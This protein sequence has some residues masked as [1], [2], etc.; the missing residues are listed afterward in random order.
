MTSFE[1][2]IHQGRYSRELKGRLG[3]VVARICLDA[4]GTVL[5]LLF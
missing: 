2:V 5:S 1:M 4:V 3:N